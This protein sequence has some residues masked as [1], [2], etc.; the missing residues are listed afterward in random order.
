MMLIIES[1][2]MQKKQKRLDF[3]TAIGFSIRGL[4]RV[5]LALESYVAS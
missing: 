4:M 5:L 2:L 3:V 1:Y